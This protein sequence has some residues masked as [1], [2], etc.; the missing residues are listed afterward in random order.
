MHI[1]LQLLG[2]DVVDALVVQHFGDFVNA[3]GIVAT[4]HRTLFHITEQSDFAAFFFG[5]NAIH[6]TNQ[7]IRLN[8]DFAQLFHRMLGRLG[9]DFARRRDIRHIAQMHKQGIAAA[10]LAA[11]LADGFQKRQRFDVAHGAADF[12][13]GHIV[14]C[15]AFVNFAL[16][17]VGNMRNH[18]HGAAQVVAAAFFGNHLL[19]HLAGAEAVAA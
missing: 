3:V 6:T 19:I 12:H 11:H 4:H 8:T 5:Q 17:F 18:L 9:F 7:Y 14:A 16:D 10:E 13:N 2:N 1:Q 15:R